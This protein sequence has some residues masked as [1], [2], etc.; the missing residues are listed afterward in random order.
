MG[1]VYILMSE[2]SYAKFTI[3]GLSLSYFLASP[4]IPPPLAN[5]VLTYVSTCSPWNS[6][7]TCHVHAHAIQP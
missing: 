4:T 6:L 1:T 7:T 3:C 2:A 5:R